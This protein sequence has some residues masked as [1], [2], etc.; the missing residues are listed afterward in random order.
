MRTS[1]AALSSLGLFTAAKE[2]LHQLIVG[3]F[4]IEKLYTLEFDDGALILDLIGNFA[5]NAASSWIASSVSR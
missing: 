1:I 5:A 2:D 3:T 4:G